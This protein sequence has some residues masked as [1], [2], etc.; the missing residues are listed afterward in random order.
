MIENMESHKNNILLHQFFTQSARRHPQRTAIDIP[1]G[2]GRPRQ[3]VTYET[4]DRHSDILA[5][6]LSAFVTKECVVAILLPRN[7]H[8]LYAAQLA[9]LKAGAAYTAIDPGF[10]EDHIRFILEDSNA[11]ALLTDQNGAPRISSSEISPDR[12]LDLSAVLT[13][14]ADPPTQPFPSPPWLKPSS[15]A[16]V[17]YTSGTTGR[18]K[19]VM[20]EHRGVS[21][22]VRSD[23][24]TFRL[25]PEDRV[26]QG[27]SAAYDSSVEELWLGLSAGATVVV[28]DDEAARLGPD[29]VSWLRQ[30]KV[31][32]LC[33]PPT[34][35]RAM[36][37]DD[38]EKSLPD[39]SLLYVG[40]EALTTDVA[41]RW[42]R[43]RNLVNGYGPTECSVTSLRGRIVAGD[44]ITIGKPISGIRAY[45]LDESLK[46]VDNGE[47]GELVL[48]GVGLARGYCNQPKL[49][50]DKFPVHPQFGRIYRTGD[51][52]HRDD[53][54]NFFYR[55]RIDSQVKI[56][57]Y[58]VELE[59]IEYR[60]LQCDK[61]REAACR[62]RGEGAQQRLE[63]FISPEGDSAPPSMH[64]IKAF[65]EKTLPSH[66]IPSRIGVLAQMPRTVGGKLN[67][68]ALPLI[69]LQE[70]GA[71]KPLAPPRDQM[72]R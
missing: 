47:A 65:L 28:M 22:L 67:R 68:D 71:T 17:I 63:A 69:D 51:L 42:A 25:S 15:L 53:E 9:V 1:P 29:L 70:E 18:P 10:P 52:V 4:L 37:S 64:N 40:G 49:T 61:V 60:L 35:L 38:P 56:R 3:T 30:E 44:A 45:V 7:S 33:P 66:M 11:L 2:K 27:S 32:V 39:L 13:N 43:G 19:G 12:V 54:G 6:H 14:S 36:G 26:V 21:N 72:E 58:R 31:T 48:G 20:I 5:K 41:D 46:V 16:Y 57:G 50:T 23:L 8:H 55:G 34:L 24:D 59:E 62:V